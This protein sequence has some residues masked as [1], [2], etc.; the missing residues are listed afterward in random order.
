MENVSPLPTVPLVCVVIADLTVS[1]A[2]GERH[3][4]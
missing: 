1:Q 4:R 2:R 3:A